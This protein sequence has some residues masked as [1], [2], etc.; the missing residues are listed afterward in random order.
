MLWKDIAGA[1]L[2]IKDVKTLLAGKNTDIKTCKNKDSKPFKCRF[3]LDTE[4]K[5]NFIFD[6]KRCI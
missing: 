6:K 3:A 5:I 1:K 2:S 4:N